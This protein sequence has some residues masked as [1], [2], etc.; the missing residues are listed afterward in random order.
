VRLQQLELLLAI[1]KTGSLRA[2]AESLHVTQPALTKALKQLEAEFGVP[3][4]LRTPQ[5]ARLAPAGELL[6]ARASTALRELERAREEVDWHVRGARARVTAGLSPVAGILLAP[7]AVARFGARM[8]QVRLRMVDAVYP[9][10]QALLR[11]GELDLAIGPLPPRETS[12][13]LVAQ[14]LFDS[15]N[16]IV[17]RA[18]HPLAQARRLRDLRDARWV[19]VGPADGPGDPAT[20]D[21]A[22]ADVAAPTVRLECESFT[23]L[24]ALLTTTD[25]VGSVPRGFLD[26][27]A[28]PMGLIE[29]AVEDRLPV[30]TLH[31]VRRADAPLTLPAQRLLD[32]F[33]QEAQSFMKRSS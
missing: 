21:W 23:T 14:P 6:A 19:L 18:G 8:P 9:R 13:D 12:R 17:A 25:V 31:A 7:G 5:G 27:F 20:I 24:L 11:S 26:R 30:T 3:L 16:V 22:R 15:A 28:K 1:A 4:V 2:S 29:I 32:D 10:A 33:V